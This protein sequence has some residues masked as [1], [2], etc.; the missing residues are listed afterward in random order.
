MCSRSLFEWRS[1]GAPGVSSRSLARKGCC[2][3]SRTRAKGGKNSKRRRRHREKGTPGKERGATRSESSCRN[4]DNGAKR[5]LSRAG[6]KCAH[7]VRRVRLY[8]PTVRSTYP[9]LWMFAQT[10]Y[11]V[12]LKFA[13]LARPSRPSRARVTS[14][15]YLGRTNKY[16]ELLWHGRIFSTSVAS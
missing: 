4:R 2:R 16:A 7:C 1:Y 15:S 9:G 13:P 6:G 5:K 10:T 12:F 14:S 8:L 3:R 11:N